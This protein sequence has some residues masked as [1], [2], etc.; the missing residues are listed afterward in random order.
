MVTPESV[1]TPD[2]PMPAAFFGHGNPMNALEV[3]RYS[4]AWRAFGE[5]VPRPRA[6]LVVSA[7]WYINATAVTAMPRPRTIHDFYGFPQELFEVQYPAPGL[8]EMAAEVSDVVHPTWVGADVDSWGIDHGTWSV[9]VHAF[10]DASIPV[11]QLSINADK[12]LDYHLE[13]GAKLAPLRKRGVL[14]VASGNVVHNLRGMDWKLTDEGYDWAQRFDEEAKTRMLTDPTEFATLDAHP[15]YR[16]AA[17]TPDHIIPALYLAGLAGATDT[18]GTDVLVDG[19]AYGSLSMT[20]YT[21]G[22][23]RPDALSGAG[24]PQPPADLPPDGSNI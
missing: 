3:N 16:R 13:L 23:R 10:P 2:T 22:L 21:L 4:S 5:S 8:P 1:N 24:S 19:Y 15:D 6:I 7:H 11:V 20:A 14:I 18:P 9:L 17:P 12:P